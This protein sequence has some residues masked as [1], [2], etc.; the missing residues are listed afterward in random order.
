[1]VVPPVGSLACAGF[2][3][4]AIGGEAGGDEPGFAE[5]MVEDGEA[6][7]KA[8]GAV[9]QFEVVHSVRAKAGFHKI[10]QVVT[11]I[12]KAAAER[13]GEVNLI[14]DFVARKQLL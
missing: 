12:A 9:R 2:V 10:F 8:N 1:M 11:P 4:R 6:V 13:E 14:N 7:V 5:V 3:A